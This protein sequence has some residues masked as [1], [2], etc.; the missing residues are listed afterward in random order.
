MIDCDAFE[1]K[2]TLGFLFYPYCTH[3]VLPTVVITSRWIL[4]WESHMMVGVSEDL[5]RLVGVLPLML[6]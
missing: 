5:N 3:R 6:A 2:S 1:R 4:Y